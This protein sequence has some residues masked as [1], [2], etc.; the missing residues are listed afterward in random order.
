MRCV[1]AGRPDNLNKSRACGANASKRG[2]RAKC[3]K[4]FHFKVAYYITFN[5]PT[6]L[7]W[8]NDRERPCEQLDNE[9][10][11]CSVDFL[12]K[13]ISRSSSAVQ[14]QSTV[15]HIITT[16]SIRVQR[17]SEIYAVTCG[18]CCI[19]TPIYIVNEIVAVKKKGT[20]PVD[21][22]ASELYLITP[23]ITHIEIAFRK[24]K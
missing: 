21:V 13:S 17:I 19:Y 11:R 3:K 18:N 10:P 24:K 23:C 6:T 15:T 1:A 7:M 9:S 16:L 5:S 20:V 2:L 8:R 14:L 4:D 12:L 22:I